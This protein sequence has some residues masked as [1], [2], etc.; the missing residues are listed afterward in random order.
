VAVNVKIIQTQLSDPAHQTALV[1]LINE[2]R[3]EP[4]GGSLPPLDAAAQMRLIEGL[5]ILPTALIFIAQ[6]RELILGMAVCFV[7]FSTFQ[8][9]PLLN[10]HDLFVTA[11]ARKRGIGRALLRAVQGHARELECCRV[12][13]EVRSDNIKAKKLYHALGFGSCKSPM[14]YWQWIAR[15]SSRHSR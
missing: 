1:A 6:E 12:T 8:A 14:E 11:T 10:I 9:Q 7:G 3:A 13:L 2:Y 15:T 4:M 5:H